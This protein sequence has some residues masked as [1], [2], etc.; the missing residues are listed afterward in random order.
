MTDPHF[1]SSAS[2]RLMS[3]IIAAASEF[4]QDLTRE[5]LAEARAGLK[6]KGRRVA[7]RVPYGYVTDRYSKQ[8]IIDPT[9]AK[10]V[11]E[12]LNLQSVASTLRRLLT[13]PTGWDGSR[14]VVVG[15]GPRG[16]C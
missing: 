13:T 9:D 4:Q 12:I 1:G 11:R 5:R 7:G 2:A 16:R 6:Q 10:R 14:G 3:N 8:L 15:C